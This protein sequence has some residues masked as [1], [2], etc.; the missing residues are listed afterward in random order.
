MGTEL[1][2]AVKD[3]DEPEVE[4]LIEIDV[5][6]NARDDNTGMSAL[7]VAAQQGAQKI[8]NMLIDAKA[9]LDIKD[10]QSSAALHMAAAYGHNNAVVSL[11]RAGAPIMLGDAVG[12]TPLHMAVQN[13]KQA[14]V[15]NLLAFGVDVNLQNIAGKTPLYIATEKGD[16]GTVKLLLKKGANIDTAID[17]ARDIEVQSIVS[18][19][20]LVKNIKDKYTDQKTQEL[21][22]QVTLGENCEVNSLEELEIQLL[23]EACEM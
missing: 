17:I 16:L 4:R 9:H 3:G 22:L 19:F 7:H 6:V 18:L 10:D 13:S 1:I 11:C 23:G 8:L 14:T 21:Y 12:N 20:D 5:D 2:E 15:K